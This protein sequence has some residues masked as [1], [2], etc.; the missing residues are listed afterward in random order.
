MYTA[1]T[2]SDTY[3]HTLSLHAALPILWMRSA[4]SR[5]RWVSVFVM[6]RPLPACPPTRKLYGLLPGQAILA[7]SRRDFRLLPVA[8]DRL[9]GRQPACETRRDVGPVRPVRGD[10]PPQ[11]A[12]K[13]LPRPPQP[14]PASAPQPQQ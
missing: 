7:G 6:P 14:P 1:T 10:Q 9:D 5:S 8:A 4:S 2:E 12:P 3:G 13:N 11:R